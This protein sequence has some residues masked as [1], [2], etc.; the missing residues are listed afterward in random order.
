MHVNTA[1]PVQLEPSGVETSRIMPLTYS[2]WMNRRLIVDLGAEAS[3]FLVV[4]VRDTLLELGPQVCQ[5][6]G[7]SDRIE[8]QV[9]IR[10]DKH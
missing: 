8:G 2:G 4:Y 10:Y 9:P 1:T 7:L 5:R 6:R 3:Y